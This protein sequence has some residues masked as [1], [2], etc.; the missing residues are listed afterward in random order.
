[1]EDGKGKKKIK[2]RLG[3]FGNAHAHAARNHVD[4]IGL[5]KEKKRS[6]QSKYNSSPAQLALDNFRLFQ[7]PDGRGSLLFFDDAWE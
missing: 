7:W 2:K 5:M 6:C 4:S 1:M 3:R